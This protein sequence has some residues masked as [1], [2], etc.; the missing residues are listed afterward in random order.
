MKKPTKETINAW[1]LWAKV[2]GQNENYASLH[3]FARWTGDPYPTEGDLRDIIVNTNNP[4]VMKKI[5]AILGPNGHTLLK[6]W[7]AQ[8]DGKIC[9]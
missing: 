6:M 4:E 3:A 9:K 2:F 8:Q 1:K 7:K 5:E